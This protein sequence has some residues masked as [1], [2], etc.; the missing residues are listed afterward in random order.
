MLKR[1]LHII[2]GD[3]ELVDGGSKFF[4]SPVRPHF[5]VYTLCAGVRACVHR[6]T[7]AG[8]CIDFVGTPTS[9]VSV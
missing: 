1:C 4:A 9:L 3:K 8:P 2:H 7:N 5:R 6:R